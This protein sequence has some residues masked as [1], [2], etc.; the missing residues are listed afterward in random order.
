MVSLEKGPS[1]AVFG[2]EAPFLGPS[3]CDGPPPLSAI[4]DVFD[5]K[6]LLRGTSPLRP[7]EGYNLYYTYFF[8]KKIVDLKLKLC[9][10]T[11]LGCHSHMKMLPQLIRNAHHSSC[12]K[13]KTWFFFEGTEFGKTL[14][15]TTVQWGEMLYLL[16]GVCMEGA[17]LVF[18][19]GYLKGP[20]VQACV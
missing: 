9:W 5:F 11:R 16:T 17:D 2:C 6:N 18:D 20:F 8:G 3:L 15:R 4:S 1:P 12:I 19:D 13:R 7:H 10:L 14:L